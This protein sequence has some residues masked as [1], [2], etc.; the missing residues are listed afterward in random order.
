MFKNLTN[1]SYKRNW[2]DAIGF[3]LA[4]L[5]LAVILGMIAGGLTGILMPSNATTFS[6]GFNQGL[7]QG[8]QIG[9]I[10]AVIYCLIISGLLLW[11]K[12]LYKN[13]GFILLAL[14][15]AF[16]AVFGA[17]LLGL[18]IPAIITTKEIK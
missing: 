4:Y 7:H 9:T 18:I 14:L 15:S 12:K 16:L 1:F 11:Q 17:S 3:Y 5:L 2:K 10:V 8:V 6:Q 13:F